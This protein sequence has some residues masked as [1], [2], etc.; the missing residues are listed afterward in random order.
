MADTAIQKRQQQQMVN[1]PERIDNGTFYTPLCDIIENDQEFI[2]QCDLPG[3]KSG[4]VDI[5]FENGVLT[6]SAKVHPRQ[7]QPNYLWREYGVGN[8]WRQ[9]TL[10]TPVDADAIKAEL[11]H[12]ELVVHVPKH[13]SARTR[14]IQ[15]KSS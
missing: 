11:R 13:E 3:V 5:L 15:I 7:D 14:K 4:D 12:G 9:F 6:I 8:F 10:A 1:V 2:F